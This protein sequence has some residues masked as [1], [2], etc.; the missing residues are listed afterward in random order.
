M[1]QET[2][3][4]PVDRILSMLTNAQKQCLVDLDLEWK[5]KGYNRVTADIL[6]ATDSKMFP[7]RFPPVVECRLHRSPGVMEQYQ[8][9][10][11]PLGD[12]LKTVLI[13]DYHYTPSEDVKPQADRLPIKHKGKPVI[14]DLE[15]FQARVGAVISKVFGKDSLLDRIVRRQRFFEESVELSWALGMT[16]EEMHA[17]VDYNCDKRAGAIPQEIAGTL[18]TLTGICVAE[19]VNMFGV[20]EDELVRIGQK[21]TQCREKEAAKPKFFTGSTWLQPK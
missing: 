5:S 14:K 1:T 9:R 19:Q 13:T 18:L 10:L 21:I 17:I 6:W 20:A 7:D 15:T 2:A 16:R 3:S 11:L 8:H 12:T 4:V